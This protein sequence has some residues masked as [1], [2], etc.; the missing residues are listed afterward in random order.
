MIKLI[1]PTIYIRLREADQELFEEIQEEAVSDYRN[2]MVSEVK[3]FEGK[4][5]EDLPCNIIIDTKFLESIEDNELAGCLGGF[6]LF[7]KK[8]RIVCSQTLDDRI[9]LAFGVAVPLIRFKL[10]PS[11]RKAE[12]A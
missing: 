12:K 7:A 11:M 9:D 10:F 8:G 6:K 3:R 5:P 1:E 2:K 4:D